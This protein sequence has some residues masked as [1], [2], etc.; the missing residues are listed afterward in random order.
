MIT[1]FEVG[2]IFKLV[3]EMSPG[4]RKILV[5]MRELNSSLKTA[6]ESMAGFSGAISGGLAGA[7]GEVNDLT[8][9]WERVAL[10]TR[11]AA[12]AARGGAT[13]AVGGGGG[14]RPGVGGRGGGGGSGPHVTGGSMKLPGI[15]GHLNLGGTPAMI[16]AGAAGYALFESSGMERGVGALKYHLGID[17][18]DTS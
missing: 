17:D 2:A 15:P 3:D 13:A 8:A 7:I 18:K 6:R 1:S 4:L 10:A 14:F 9:A 16:G 12:L 5:S 11:G